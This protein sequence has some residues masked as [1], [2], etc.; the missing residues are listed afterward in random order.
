M[1]TKEQRNNDDDIIVCTNLKNLKPCFY[2]DKFVV[3][4]ATPCFR[5]G[6]HTQNPPVYF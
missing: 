5:K 4:V 2:A 6:T 1:Y 3:T